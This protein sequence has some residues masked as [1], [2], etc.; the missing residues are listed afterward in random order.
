MSFGLP[1]RTVGFIE[2]GYVPEQAIC[3]TQK[4]GGDAFTKKLLAES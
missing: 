2:L 3:N 4:L 1:L